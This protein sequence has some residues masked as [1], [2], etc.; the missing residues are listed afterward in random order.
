[1]ILDDLEEIIFKIREVQNNPL[2]NQ[3]YMMHM[4][5]FNAECEIDE[6]I[7]LAKEIRANDIY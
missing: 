2:C 6:A 3:Y 4:N 5:L 7:R 1:M